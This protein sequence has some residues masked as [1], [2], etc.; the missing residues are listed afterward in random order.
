MVVLVLLLGQLQQ[1]RYVDARDLLQA[2]TPGMITLA[3]APGPASAKSGGGL[4]GGVIAAIVVVAIVVVAFIVVKS[5]LLGWCLMRR[6]KRKQ[7]EA[8]EKIKLGVQHQEELERQNAIPDVTK[9]KP[10]IYTDEGSGGISSTSDDSSLNGTGNV[11]R[12]GRITGNSSEQSSTTMSH[13]RSDH[14]SQASNMDRAITIDPSEIELEKDANGNF[15][16]L[17]VGTYGRVYKGLRHGTTEVA[18]KKLIADDSASILK[19]FRREINVLHQLSHDKHIVQFYGKCLDQGNTML[20]LEYMEGGDLRNALMEDSMGSYRWYGK[21]RHLA[22]GVAKGMNYLHTHGVIH[23]DLKSKNILLTRDGGDAKI[24]DVGLARIISS[25][26]QTSQDYAFGTFAYAA[27]E[28]LLGEKCD[29][30]A[31]IY[32]FGVVLWELATGEAPQRGQLRDVKVPEECPLAVAE[33]I[34]KCLKR[35]PRLRPSAREVCDILQ[36]M[37]YG[38]GPAEP[39]EHPESEIEGQQPAMI[40][41]DDGEGELEEVGVL[42]NGGGPFEDEIL[43]SVAMSINSD[44]GGHMSTAGVLQSREGAG[45]ALLISTGMDDRHLQPGTPQGTLPHM[46]A[47]PTAHMHSPTTDH[48]QHEAQSPI[49]VQAVPESMAYAQYAN[50]PFAAHAQGHV[51]SSTTPGTA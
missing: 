38:S 11:I 49:P 30:K 28:L 13:S 27:P 4:S 21:G 10:H 25:A 36:A 15:V 44:G 51:G 1:A 29:Y 43:E 17:G 3:P 8:I 23:S 12:S 31:D 22:H 2:G 33:L 6:E 41:E 46:T 7:R 47:K 50:S 32:S 48:L 24:G 39:Y 26:S 40:E 45:Q 35:R 18:V 16:L 37:P 42:G 19:S 20:V 9:G 5:V 34:E 14:S